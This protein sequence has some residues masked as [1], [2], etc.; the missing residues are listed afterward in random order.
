M[1]QDCQDPETG[2][3]G[4]CCRDPNYKDPW[5]ASVLGQYRPDLLGFDD[6]TY[7]Q[8]NK[9]QPGVKGGR[10]PVPRPNQPFEPNQIG[11]PSNNPNSFIKPGFPANNPNNPFDNR[12][13]NPGNPVDFRPPFE[14]DYSQ[15][16]PTSVSKISSE[17]C[18]V[19]H[20]VSKLSLRR[21][22]IFVKLFTN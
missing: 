2:V 7:K 14:G 12:Q 10:L 3:I 20:P 11:S 1:L 22:T 4:K 15:K 18:G 8:K 17:T 21:T 13:V 16:Y 6:G 9:P 19:R 5:P